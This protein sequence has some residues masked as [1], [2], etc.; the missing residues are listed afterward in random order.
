MTTSFA[1]NVV[2]FNAQ[3]NRLYYP[4]EHIYRK[5]YCEVECFL[6]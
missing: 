1:H 4:A 2:T 3:K 6:I 5:Y